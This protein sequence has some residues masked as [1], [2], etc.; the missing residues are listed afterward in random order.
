MEGIKKV[1]SESRICWALDVGELM[2]FVTVG[3][4]VSEEIVR[5]VDEIAPKLSDN[6]LILLGETKYAPKNCK[7]IRSVPS[8]VPFVKK[9]RLVIAHG[10][11]GTLF[12]CLHNNARVIAIAK[13]HAANHQTDIINKLSNEGYIIK[14]ETLDSLESCILNNKKLKRYEQPRCDIPKLVSDFLKKA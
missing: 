1:L 10:G 2:I 7:Y 9:A 4:G 5:K 6:V 3:M 14:C 12:E 8:I 13:K 11:A